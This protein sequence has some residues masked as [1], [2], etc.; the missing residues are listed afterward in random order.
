[1]SS[2]RDRTSPRSRRPLS[3][4]AVAGLALAVLAALAALL[5]GPVYRFDGWSLGTAFA[6]LRWAAY[7]GIAAAAV[8]LVGAVLARPGGPRRGFPYAVAGLAVGLAVVGV[9]LSYLQTARSVPPIHDI[10]TDTDDPPRFEAI[11]PLRAE[12][13]NPAAYAGEE[14]AARQRAAYPDI[15]PATVPAPPDE[16]FERAVAVARGMGWEVVAAEEDAGR[17]EATGTTFWFGFKDDVV[18]RIRPAG[19]GSRV[20]VRSKSRV[21]V[22]DLGVNAVRVRRFLDELRERG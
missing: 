14:V 19:A 5:P 17:I 13:P 6:V 12:A 20:D 11:L 18:V 10:T 15:A 2:A 3:R 22:G 7:A 4:V 16:A 8:S 9:P 1:M 21:G